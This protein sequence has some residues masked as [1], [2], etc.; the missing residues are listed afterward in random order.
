MTGQLIRNWISLYLMAV[1]FEISETAEKISSGK[2][3]QMSMSCRKFKSAAKFGCW[4][5]CYSLRRKLKSWL[6]S[7]S[8]SSNWNLRSMTLTGRWYLYFTRLVSM[9]PRGRPQKVW[10][11]STPARMVTGPDHAWARERQ[12]MGFLKERNEREKQDNLNRSARLS[13]CCGKESV[14]KRPSLEANQP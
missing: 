2:M 4:R 5:M 6:K 3:N 11:K 9:S 10:R 14:V 12:G 13:H 8:T 7:V 1:N